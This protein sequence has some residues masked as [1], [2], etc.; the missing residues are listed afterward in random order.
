MIGGAAAIGYS[1]IDFTSILN[2]ILTKS[3]TG[4]EQ[5]GIRP[6]FIFDDDT[7][8]IMGY[9]C[10]DNTNRIGVK[11]ATAPY[12]DPHNWTK[13]G[14]LVLNIGSNFGSASSPVF[15]DSGSMAIAYGNFSDGKI[16]LAEGAD[17]DNLTVTGEII[18]NTA[19]S[20]FNKYMRHPFCI[21]KDDTV[22]MFY[23]ARSDAANS[24]LLSKVGVATADISD[25]T[26]WTLDPTPVIDPDS[27]G[28][29][30]GAANPCVVQVGDSYLMMFSAIST[31]SDKLFGRGGG[32]GYATSSDLI[33]WTVIT[34]EMFLEYL[35]RPFNTWGEGSLQE[36]TI[37]AESP[38]LVHLYMWSPD[39]GTG[40]D[41]GGIGYG[42][43]ISGTFDDTFPDA[44]L[45]E[46]FTGNQIDTNEWTVVED[47]GI[48]IVQTG[49]GK[50][51]ITADGSQNETTWTRRF[52]GGTSFNTQDHF[53]FSFIFTRTPAVHGNP[54]FVIDMRSSDQNNWVGF[55]RDLTSGQI[56]A[57]V[58][59]GGAVH[60]RQD[61]AVSSGDRLK[62][63]VFGNLVG[64]FRW[65]G[66]KWAKL[67]NDVITDDGWEN[68]DLFF[69]IIQNNLSGTNTVMTIDD[70]VIRQHDHYKL[71]KWDI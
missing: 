44:L 47:S 1:S 8:W 60:I 42:T 62:C 25:L 51:T 48:T 46:P 54:A 50:L 5:K 41:K 31:T 21:R 69:T 4:N 70:L 38:S 9:F 55:V 71:D 12:N 27:Y 61:I 28:F 58:N 23:D 35:T 24:T 49:D 52:I 19:S 22:Y 43:L 67:Y 3:G 34:D 68:T 64:W 26:A 63:V 17:I 18:D 33:S 7:Q 13:T 56:Q 53:A 29:F 11:T 2:P 66:S 16:Y 30:E 10:E 15:Y 37:F 32:V 39:F 36:F 45:E 40:S 57:A 20:G 6:N 14:N 59:V 65:D